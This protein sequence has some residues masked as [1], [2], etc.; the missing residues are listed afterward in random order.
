MAAV[1]LKNV[2]LGR[3]D[4]SPEATLNL[5]IPDREFV[6]LTGP[7]GC[8][9]STILRM[10]AGLE[11]GTGEIFLDER[12]LDVVS[13]RDREVAL[14]PKDYAPYPRLSVFDNLAFSLR[15]RSFPKGEVE[16]RVRSAAEIA[17]LTEMLQRNAQLLD[18]EQRQRIAL[19]RAMALQPKVFLFDEPFS[20]LE[21]KMRMTGRGE[22][23]K[24]HQRQPATM[25]YATHD[26]MEAMA[27][28]GRIVVFARGIVQQDGN[29]QSVYEEPANLFVAGF[30]GNPG[31]NLV[32]GILKQDRDSLLF[33]EEGDGTIQLRLAGPKFLEARD[34]AGK[35]VV[36]GFRPEDV[37]ISPSPA[38]RSA[39][40]FRALVE[41]VEP[42][43]P[44]IDLYLQ[45]GA[46]T[47]LCRSAGGNFDRQGGYRAQFEVNLDKAH[48]FDTESRALITRKP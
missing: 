14:V 45:T 12:L 24:L 32:H 1:V 8:G 3:S 16:K 30:I 23:K 18:K 10:I 40:G 28:G 44:E 42:K 22:I 15:R 21:P 25:I 2:S 43:G 33:T 37:A 27:M 41:R 39:S 4:L 5:E 31:M 29:A 17:G 20:M 38:E 36:F 46:H 6:V 13:P 26:P 11:S 47:L 48:L 34:F 9:V 19:A 35:A 7:P